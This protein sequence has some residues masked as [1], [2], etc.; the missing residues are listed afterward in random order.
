MKTSL[1]FM[2]AISS[3]LLYAGRKPINNIINKVDR[4]FLGMALI[5]FQRPYSSRIVSCCVLITLEFLSIFVFKY[6]EFNIHL[7]VVT[8]HLFIV[9]FGMD[10]STAGFPR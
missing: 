9:S 10:L 2:A 8:W 5:Y 3:N 1:E 6:Q 7:N 4:I